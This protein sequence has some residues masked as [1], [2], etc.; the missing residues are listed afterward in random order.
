MPWRH[1]DIISSLSFSHSGLPLHGCYVIR[2]LCK[3]HQVSHGARIRPKKMAKPRGARPVRSKLKKKGEA[4]T[5]SSSKRFLVL[6]P[7]GAVCS[8]HFGRCVHQ[9]RHHDAITKTHL[10]SQDVEGAQEVGAFN[11]RLAAGRNVPQPLELVRAGLPGTGRGRR[12]VKRPYT[13]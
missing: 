11:G 3:L 1:H 2:Y 10:E 13:I 12:K 5:F 9:W 7:D 8:E 4:L 6:A